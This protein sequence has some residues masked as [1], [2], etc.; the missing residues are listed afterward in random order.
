MVNEQISTTNDVYEI[1]NSLKYFERVEK[2]LTEVST[3]PSEPRNCNSYK[4]FYNIGKYQ[5]ISVTKDETV[6][7]RK[8]F[9]ELET[10]YAQMHKSLFKK[11]FER[12]RS[13]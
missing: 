6:E 12:K 4:P 7:C 3:E 8:G 11:L 10:A 2:W 9:Q 1:T 5:K 13:I